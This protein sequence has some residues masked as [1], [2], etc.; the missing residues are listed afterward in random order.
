MWF[1]TQTIHYPK[2]DDPQQ[3]IDNYVVEVVCTAD[4]DSEVVAGR[5]AID[6]LDLMR[7]NLSSRDV[8]QIADA[9]SGGWEGL[10]AVTLD[11]DES[12][13]QIR[14]DFAVQDCVFGFGFIYEACFHP[15]LRSMQPFMVDAVCKTFP[16]ESLIFT[17][18]DRTDLSSAERAN[19]GFRKVAQT[20]YQFRPNMLKTD[21]E[22]SSLDMDSITVPCDAEDYV[23][24]R[25]S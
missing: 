5:L 19:L 8:L 14:D 6:Y 21:F 12:Q 20:N 7:A 22:S 18:D 11:L 1:K 10:C 9:D 23:N 2:P 15:S 17:F 16:E 13:P 24:S 4:N 25:W 3:F